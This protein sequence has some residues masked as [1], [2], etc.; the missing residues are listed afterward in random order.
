M[1]E[2]LHL[3]P[4]APYP[5]APAPSRRSAAPGEDAPGRPDTGSAIRV[6]PESVRTLAGEASGVTG[7]CDMV[8]QPARSLSAWR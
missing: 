8:G 1:L 5:S 2:G 4:A 3:P 6:A 7:P